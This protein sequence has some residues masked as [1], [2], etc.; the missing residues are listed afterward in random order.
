MKTGVDEKM[1][2]GFVV[3]FTVLKKDKEKV[4]KLVEDNKGIIIRGVLT[5]TEVKFM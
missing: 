5:Q 1:E 4:L 3:Q 2:D